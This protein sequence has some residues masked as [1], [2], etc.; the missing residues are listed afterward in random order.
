MCVHHGQVDRVHS[1][2]RGRNPT[3]KPGVAEIQ[4]QIMQ[5][6]VIT[7]LP[8]K[9]SG[10]SRTVSALGLV[11]GLQLMFAPVS[12]Q[13]AVCVDACAPGPGDGSPADPYSTLSLAVEEAANGDRLVLESGVYVETLVIGKALTS[14]EGGKGLVLVLVSLQ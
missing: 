1:K 5:S 7:R 8:P 13:A 12:A 6:S 2:W 11:L 4:G 9:T 10:H 14:L 3:L